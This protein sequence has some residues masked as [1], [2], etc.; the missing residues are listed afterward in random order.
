MKFR[1][2]EETY[3]LSLAQPEKFWEESASKYISL[4][5]KSFG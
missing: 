5:N 2:Y 3:N 1:T 4:G